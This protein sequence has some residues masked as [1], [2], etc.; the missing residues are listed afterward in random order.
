MADIATATAG[1]RDQF[2]GVVPFVSEA[3]T[4]SDP[5]AG[6]R[7]GSVQLVT[8]GLIDPMRCR[9][10]S[11]P[12][13][14]AG[15]RWAAPVVE[16]GLLGAADPGLARWARQRLVPKVLLA[17]QTRVLEPAVDT[18]GSWWPSVPTISV[19]PRSGTVP[20]LWPIAAVL[21]SPAVSVW[22]MSRSAGTALSRHAIK[23]SARQVLEIPLP[24]DDRAW[25]TGARLAARA[26]HA[27]RI[28]DAGAWRSALTSLGAAMTTAYS[29]SDEVLA[30]WLERLPVWR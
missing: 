14:F 20:D 7:G 26:H 6:M 15:R 11:A 16:L 1:F 21:A 12:T 13:R 24:T 28:G 10:G 27:A 5:P 9:W 25:S 4:G 30:W 3:V 29:S 8:A 19:V 23:L 18:E 17:T 2:Y 22:A